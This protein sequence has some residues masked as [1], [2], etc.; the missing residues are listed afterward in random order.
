[1]RV[2]ARPVT[3][4]LVEAAPGTDYIRIGRTYACANDWG[5]ARYKAKKGRAVKK[6][7][8]PTYNRAAAAM[9]AG[10]I[11]AWHIYEDGWV[12]TATDGTETEAMTLAEAARYLDAVETAATAD[13]RLA[14]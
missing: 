3:V 14:A 2:T 1:M 8:R 6:A 10:L 9:L 5:T 7:E 12:F 11:H 13:T 4:R